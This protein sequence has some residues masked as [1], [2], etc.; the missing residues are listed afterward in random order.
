ML[1]AFGRLWSWWTESWRSVGRARLQYA[2][3]ALAFGALA[4]IA[5]LMS[6]AVVAA[7]AG[8]AA[9]ICVGLAM[10][11]PRLARVTTSQEGHER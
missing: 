1:I 7:V 3:M 6:E 10:L 5:A 2:A 4:V 11:A 8:I 9:A